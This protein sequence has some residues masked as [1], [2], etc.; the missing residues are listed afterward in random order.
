M[1]SIILPTV[2]KSGSNLI[3]TYVLFAAVLG[4]IGFVAYMLG[5]HKHRTSKAKKRGLSPHTGHHGNH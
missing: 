3:L 5:R 1:N 2:H 4:A